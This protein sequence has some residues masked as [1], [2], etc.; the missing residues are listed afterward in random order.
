[1]RTTVTLDDDVERLLRDVMRAQGLS[2]KE[3]LNQAAREGL[4]RERQLPAAPFV[5]RT[6][7]LGPEEGFRWEKA[8]AMAD[9]MEDEELSRKLILRK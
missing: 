4:M 1:M 7:R 9:A 6:F 3:A 5:Q 8:L 2:F